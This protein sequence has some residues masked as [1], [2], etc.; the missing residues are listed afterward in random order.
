VRVFVTGASGWIGS[1]LVPELL[2]A[3]HQVVGLARSD[4]S[5]AALR[6]V[7]AEVHP[8]SLDDPGGLARAAA[9]SDGVIHLAFKV[10]FDNFTASAATD[11]ATIQALGAALEG[12]GKPLVMTTGTLMIP[13]LAPGRTGTEDI[14]PPAGTRLPRV[15]SEAAALALVPRGVRASVVRLAP[16]VH[17][18][19]DRGFIP[20]LIGI[21]R[22][23]GVAGYL[24]DG[25]NRWPAVHR[26]DAA[27]LYR[28]GLESAPAGSILHGVAEEGIAFRDIAAAIGAQLGVP[29][30]PVG[31]GHFGFLGAFAG[32]DN[33]VSSALTR[34]LL[35]WQP[36]GPGL[37]DDLAT[38]HYFDPRVRS[39]F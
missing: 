3:G 18:E 13:L 30:G 1:A 24:G 15:A 5:A 16:T 39:K 7:G 26:Q 32:T 23:T 37:L 21:A 14:L 33:P 11:V 29:A 8:G 10:D 2:G 36:S 9:V 4:A 25:A 27:R 35:D 20:E 22:E 17:A 6:A 34:K 12:T 38:G 31:P 28:L 19:G